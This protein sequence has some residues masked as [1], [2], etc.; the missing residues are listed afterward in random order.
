MAP[1][2]SATYDAAASPELKKAIEADFGSLDGLKSKFN[3]AATGVFG[4]GWA[5][6][7]V[8]GSG[9]LVVTSTPNQV[10]ALVFKIR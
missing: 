10:G 1:G 4:S 2:G 6:L 5:W 7:G 9:K 3:T 8:D